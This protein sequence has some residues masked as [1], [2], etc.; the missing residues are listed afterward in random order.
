MARRS[1]LK[2][3]KVS[4]YESYVYNY[5]GQMGNMITLSL[6][7]KQKEKIDVYPDGKRLF[8]SRFYALNGSC[9]VVKFGGKLWWQPFGAGEKIYE[10]FIG[11]IGNRVVAAMNKPVP[12]RVM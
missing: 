9:P 6:T 12:S 11:E 7:E 4:R 1:K 3:R 2:A 8:L 5:G 10:E